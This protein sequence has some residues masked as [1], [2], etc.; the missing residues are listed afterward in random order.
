MNQTNK[1]RLQLRVIDDWSDGWKWASV[2]FSAASVVINTVGAIVLKGAAAAASVLGILPMRWALV[3]GASVSAS[4][5]I[6]R[7]LTTK[8]KGD[9]GE[10][11]GK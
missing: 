4:A 3:I 5:L 6:G 2:H 1:P 7:F 10:A 9:Q 8:P 11:D